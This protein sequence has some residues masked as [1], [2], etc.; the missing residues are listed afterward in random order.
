MRINTV[1]VYWSARHESVEVC[2]QRLGRYLVSLKS[3]FPALAEWYKRSG[4]ASQPVLFDKNEYGQLLDILSAG[5]NKR[6]VNGEIIEELGFRVGLW[7]KRKESEAIGL[8]I[9]CGLFSNS[10][11]LSNAVTLSLPKDLE[12]LSL[13]G[14]G[15][16]RKLLLLQ[17]EAWNPDWGAVFASQSD[18]VRNR[19]GNGPFLDKMLW[20]KDGVTLPESVD[21]ECLKEAVLGGAIC[22]R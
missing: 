17:V 18:A 13:Q 3:A 9:T 21:K 5:V 8:G 7:N 20:V 16:L 19:K 2:A 11:G 6:D 4:V 10:A 12:A 22:V 15:A 14:E 1:G